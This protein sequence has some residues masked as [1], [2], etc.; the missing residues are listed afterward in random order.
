VVIFFGIFQQDLLQC[1]TKVVHVGTKKIVGPWLVSVEAV[2]LSEDKDTLLRQKALEDIDQLMTGDI[3]Y[4]LE[5]TVENNGQLH[6]LQI[7]TDTFSKQTRPFCFKGCDLKVEK[8]LPIVG[9]DPSVTRI[10]SDPARLNETQLVKV[11]LKLKS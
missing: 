11:T 9:N 8:T 2:S 5:T 3:H 7:I 6:P 1:T 4:Y 10:L